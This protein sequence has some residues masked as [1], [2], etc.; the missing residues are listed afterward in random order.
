MASPL[1]ASDY[2]TLDIARLQ[3]LEADP[4]L[5]VSQWAAIVK[6][7]GR[8]ASSPPEA[9][10]PDV[11]ESVVASTPTASHGQTVGHPAALA[12]PRV[13]LAGVIDLADQH[14]VRLS[15]AAIAA[16]LLVA[17]I[18]WRRS[19]MALLAIA[20]PLIACAAIVF[21]STSFATW[22]NSHDSRLRRLDGWARARPTRARRYLV[23]PLVS[24]SLWTWVQSER[25][26]NAGVRAGLRFTFI[27]WLLLAAVTAIVTAVYFVVAVV[28]LGVALAV[29]SWVMHVVANDGA[30]EMPRYES[31]P[32]RPRNR[33]VGLPGSGPN[34][35]YRVDPETGVVQ[36]RGLFGWADT[37]R[38]VDPTSGV[39]QDRGIVGWADG[40]QRIDPQSGDIQDRGMIG[41]AGTGR[42]VNPESGVV[43]EW[44]AFGWADTNERFDPATGVRQVR[45]LTGWID[46]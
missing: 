12:A 29:V 9:A 3:A 37:K 6:E 42:R 32:V 1:S 24:L 22:V 34:H 13:T 28:L 45:G 31:T 38:R 41:W 35:G 18:V 8:R 16:G 4:S 43:Q 7:L 36:E 33:V 11:M 20:P 27:L 2:S 15:A 39:V 26:L 10:T 17:A 21:G 44:G 19:G 46:A 30:R 40:K 14:R 5:D 23:A 25:V